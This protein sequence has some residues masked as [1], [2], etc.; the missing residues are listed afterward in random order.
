LYPIWD[1]VDAPAGPAVCALIPGTQTRNASKHLKIFV[2][3]WTLVS[4]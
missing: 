2:A 4:L 3:M 1:G